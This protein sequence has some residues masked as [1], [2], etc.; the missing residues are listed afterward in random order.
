MICYKVWNGNTNILSTAIHVWSKVKN[1]SDVLKYLYVFCDPLDAFHRRRS[2]HH[3]YKCFITWLVNA[4]VTNQTGQPCLKSS[5]MFTYPRETFS[6]CKCAK[7][8]NPKHLS[9]QLFTLTA[10]GS[11]PNGEYLNQCFHNSCIYGFNIWP[12]WFIHTVTKI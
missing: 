4:F 1:I 10:N 6:I 9:W 7:P 8:V 11:G 2:D 12:H 5:K 3:K